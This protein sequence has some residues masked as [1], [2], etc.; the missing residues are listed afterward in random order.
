[1]MLVEIVTCLSKQSR[2]FYELRLISF[3]EIEY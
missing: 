1:M 2:N 3:L